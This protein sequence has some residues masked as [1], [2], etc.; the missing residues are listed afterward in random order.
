M[1]K[2]HRSQF[3]RSVVLCS[4]VSVF[5]GGF[6]KS[7]AHTAESP[8]SVDVKS[9]SWWLARAAQEAEAIKPS[10][11]RREAFKLLS[12]TQ[13]RAGDFDGARRSAEAI[14]PS[15]ERKKAFRLLSETRAEA[16]D[17]DGARRWASEWSTHSWGEVHFYLLEATA[18]FESGDKAGY[19]S[20][21]DKASTLAPKDYFNSDMLE[22]YLNC[23][24]PNGA[25]IYVDSLTTPEQL[26]EAHLLIKQNAYLEI[27]CHWACNGQMARANA[28]LDAHFDGAD[29]RRVLALVAEM[30]AWEGKVSEAEQLLA[31]MAKIEPSAGES[32]PA[33]ALEDMY[34]QEARHA[35]GRA[36]AEA[37]NI[38]KA[39]VVAETV[40]ESQSRSRLLKAIA[41]A[42]VRAGDVEA[43][44]AMLKDL[45]GRYRDSVYE[46]IITEQLDKGQLDAAAATMQAFAR[47]AYDN[48]TA[49]ECYLALAQ[50]VGERG[51]MPAYRNFLQ[52]AVA[53]AERIR[54]DY[55]LFAWVEIFS[56]LRDAGD[57]LGMLTIAITNDDE[58]IRS[59]A[60]SQA[61]R[62]LSRD[63]DISTAKALSKRITSDYKGSAYAAVAR[64][65]VRGDRVTEAQAFLNT[66]TDSRDKAEAYRNTARSLVA[67]DRQEVLIEWLKSIDSPVVRFNVCLGAAQAFDDDYRDVALDW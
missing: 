21:I 41:L 15:D 34:E 32:R 53:R 54:S 6:A 50:A 61:V 56:V 24:D 58:S 47:T 27:A 20:C 22:V 7:I 29:K 67:M 30:C 48:R 12:K 33:K 43:A 4:F 46:A 39:R 18:C 9:A 19:R 26:R 5:G 64:A 16:G 45:P 37:G 52:R 23:Q 51:G 65:L 63:G 31:K 62:T 44:E 11:E 35:L 13:A 1:I 28:V 25:T 2:L 14:E 59:W 40:P 60:L 42:H 57:L 38:A 55:R 10:D 49:A 3:L 66:L 36:Y 8:V 17:F